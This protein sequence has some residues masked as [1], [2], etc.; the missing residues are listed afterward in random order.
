M[1]WEKDRCQGQRRECIDYLNHVAEPGS[2]E[3]TASEP[4]SSEFLRHLTTDEPENI[5]S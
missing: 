4:S 3:P 2:S 5:N 1:S